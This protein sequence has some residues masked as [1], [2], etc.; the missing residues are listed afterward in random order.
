MHN[1]RRTASIRASLA[2]AAALGLAAC[3]T[4]VKTG[5][6]GKTGTT[7]TTAKSAAALPG[8]GKPPI[9]MGDK[10]FAEE[11]ILGDLYTQA[12]QAKGYTVTL[13]SDIGSSEIIS[14][15]LLS[16]KIQM[17]PEY[18]GVIYQTLAGHSTNPSSAAQT[19]SGSQTYENSNGYTIL[20]ATPFQD[21]D[22]VAV[23]NAFA[24]KHDLV[25]TADLKK[26]G[27][28]TYGGPPENATRYQGVVGLK[29]AYGLNKIQFKPIPIGSQYKA[30]DQGK[31][32]TIA[33]FTT[34]PQLLSNKYTVLTDPKDIFGFQQVV[35][36]VKTS[37]IKAEGPAFAMTLNAVSATLTDKVVQQLDQAV[38]IDQVGAAT[39]AE[40]FLQANGLA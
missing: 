38:E 9:V 10:N 14:K 1:T 4:T 39:V 15:A 31:V 3:G 5:N 18:T 32:D 16:G 28:F 7:S 13:K 36:V 26:L 2:L 23:T 40:K 37:L 19:Y 27:A 8:K 22:R 6:T 20:K 24:K 35:P 34:D 21:A 17:Y 12:L 29:Q 33:V 11:Y 25:S 30:L